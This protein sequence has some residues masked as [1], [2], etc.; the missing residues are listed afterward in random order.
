VPHAI[1]DVHFED[2]ER[3]RAASDDAFVKAITLCSNEILSSHVEERY[4]RIVCRECKCDELRERRDEMPRQWPTRGQLGLMT[5]ASGR[6]TPLL[7]PISRLQEM[8]R[9]P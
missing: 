4:R 5:L 1:V 2:G 8:A 7:N 9:F 3:H 6:Q